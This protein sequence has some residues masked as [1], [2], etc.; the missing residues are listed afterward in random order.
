MVCGRLL[1]K[2]HKSSSS[3]F[4]LPTSLSRYHSPFHENRTIRKTRGRHFCVTGDRFHARAPASFIGRIATIPAILRRNDSHIR[5]E[6]ASY[7]R[8]YNSNARYRRPGGHDI[9][10][11][12]SVSAHG[13]L[14][15]GGTRG[16]TNS[17]HLL[18]SVNAQ[19]RA[20]KRGWINPAAYSLERGGGWLWPGRW[21]QKEHRGEAW[22]TG[23]KQR[24]REAGKK[25]TF[26]PTTV[27][28]TR[29]RVRGDIK[30]QGKLL[31][32]A[33][34]RAGRLDAVLPLSGPVLPFW[35]GLVYG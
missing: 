13:T 24:G 27:N 29:G 20:I 15:A 9:T 11:C 26:R 2:L 3:S 5:G 34:M 23:R 14:C 22:C 18:A 25:R 17:G 33:T 10:G 16:R 19:G 6:C 30:L 8:T 35:R 1:L 7:S 32:S 31:S 28:W 4:S 21:A 12:R